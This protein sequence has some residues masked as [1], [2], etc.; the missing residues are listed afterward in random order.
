MRGKA[1][2][3]FAFESNNSVDSHLLN[4]H[5]YWIKDENGH[6]IE[7][8]VFQDDEECTRVITYG[9][10]IESSGINKLKKLFLLTIIDQ[11]SILF[12]K[13]SDRLLEYYEKPI[14]CTTNLSK[15]ENVIS[16][17]TGISTNNGEVNCYHHGEYVGSIKVE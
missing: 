2:A 8:P 11:L 4:S 12:K 14:W 5:A 9:T 15:V 16:N 6:L 13:N 7:S 3:V 1:V 17:C 10:I